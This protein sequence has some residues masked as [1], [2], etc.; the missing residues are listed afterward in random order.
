M[1]G[2]FDTRVYILLL[3]PLTFVLLR[4]YYC[5][6]YSNVFL[7]FYKI[8]KNLLEKAVQG[9]CSVA[10]SSLTL[11]NPLDYSL[12][13]SFVHGLFQAGILEWVA[14][15]SSSGSSRPRDQTCVSCIG[16]QILYPSAT[17]EAQ[18]RACLLISGCVLFPWCMSGFPNQT[19]KAGTSFIHSASSEHLIH[20]YSENTSCLKRKWVP[21]LI[22]SHTVLSIYQGTTVVDPFLLRPRAKP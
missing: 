21:F 12:P 15:S 18:F 7:I 17:W 5:W 22:V 14:I 20:R 10:Q 11:C 13:G 9:L 3:S 2:W 16:R 1:W 19:L 4:T 8:L 6:Y